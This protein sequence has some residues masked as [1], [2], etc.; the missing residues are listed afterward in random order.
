MRILAKTGGKTT[1]H[2]LPAQPLTVVLHENSIKVEAPEALKIDPEAT[3]KCMREMSQR[4]WVHISTGPLFQDLFQTL[5][6]P[7]DEQHGNVTLP[8]EIKTLLDDYD[9]GILHACGLIIMLVES[10]LEGRDKVFIKNPETHLHPA[11][12][13]LLV[14]LIKKIQRIPGPGDAPTIEVVEEA[15]L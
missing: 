9:D 14:S 10:R 15:L 5:Y 12:Q 2:E 3:I 8:A 7:D 11:Q 1:E 4:A 6:P 13:R